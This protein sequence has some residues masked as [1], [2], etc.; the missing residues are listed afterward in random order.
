MVQEN[1]QERPQPGQ[2]RQS[3]RAA[4]GWW[5]QANYRNGESDRY[6]VVAWVEVITGVWSSQDPY[7]NTYT[8]DTSPGAWVVT[9]DGL[10]NTVTDWGAEIPASYSPARFTYV[11]AD[12]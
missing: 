2:I 1:A 11:M 7:A 10:F 6:P 4:P 12:A 9:P 8:V 5:A 3:V